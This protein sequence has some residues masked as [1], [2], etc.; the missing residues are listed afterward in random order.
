MAADYFGT[1]VENGKEN[2]SRQ[3]LLAQAIEQCSAAS[4]SHSIGDTELLNC[5]LGADLV[6]LSSI[7]PTN[8]CWLKLFFVN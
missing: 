3:H 7:T 1:D 8:G 2:D 6:L 5:S 4:D